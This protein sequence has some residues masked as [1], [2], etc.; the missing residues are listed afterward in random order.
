MFIVC[1]RHLSL[2][3]FQVF[4]SYQQNLYSY[5]KIELFVSLTISNASFTISEVLIELA[6]VDNL[7]YTG[8]YAFMK[9]VTKRDTG[10]RNTFLRYL[11]VG[12]GF[13]FTA[14]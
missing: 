14:V 12:V 2:H 5:F 7:V 4:D 13:S 3:Y 9:T 11:A 10:F 8:V 6:N 1:L